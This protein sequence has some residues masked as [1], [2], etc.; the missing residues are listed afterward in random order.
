MRETRHRLL[1]GDARRLEALSDATI[2]LVV[3]SPPYPMIAMWDD[4]FAGLDPAIGTLLAAGEG[5]GAF[6]GMHR[7]LDTAWSEMHRVLRPGGIACVNIGDATRSIAG[8]FSL[9]PNHARILSSCLAA[10]FECLPLILWRKQTNAPTKFMGSGMLPA[11]AYVTLEHEYILVLRKGPKREFSSAG[12][13]ERRRRSAFFWEERNTW[14]SDLWDLKGARQA[15]AGAASGRDGERASAE[16]QAA[17]SRS[18]AFPFELAYRLISMYSVQGDT[19]LD[20]FAGTGTTL[21]AA[22]CAGRN[23]IGIEID[24]QLA[25]GVFGRRAENPLKTELVRAELNAYLDERLARHR[26][27]VSRSR[28]SEGSPR[29]EVGHHNAP[30]D[31][32]VVTG[33]ETG[34]A[35]DLIDEIRADGEGV[36]VATYR[37]A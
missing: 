29:R 1:C 34:L 9:Y 11:G 35:I 10:G 18:G 13:R 3:T 2:D 15:L 14:Y 12:E 26:D 22:L 21:W 16:L 27:F 19:V 37:E 23:S 30:H 33:Q 25:R 20:P 32:P 6:E 17:R 31:T 8:S 24:S 28:S 4:L 36:L 7:L 5:Q